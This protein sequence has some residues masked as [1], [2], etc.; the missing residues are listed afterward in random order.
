MLI[1]LNDIEL[2]FI[3]QMARQFLDS[4]R[5]NALVTERRAV[6]RSIHEKMT[7]AADEVF[8]ERF[9]LLQGEENY[10]THG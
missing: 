1:D 3:D 10:A 5:S 6:A 4:N 7:A 8:A 2:Y 9:D